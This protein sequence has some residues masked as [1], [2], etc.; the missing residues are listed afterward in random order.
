MGRR[1]GHFHDVR[2]HHNSAGA[3]RAANIPGDAFRDGDG[4]PGAHWKALDDPRQ[5][6]Y[7]TIEFE[8]RPQD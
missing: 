4:E 6:F 1:V 7:P 8:S 3:E 2:D 5:H